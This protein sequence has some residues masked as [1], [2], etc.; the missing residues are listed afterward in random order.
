MKEDGIVVMS[1]FDGIGTGLLALK[2]AGIKVKKYYASEIE[3]K[4]MVVARNNHPEI[5]EIGDVKKICVDE[6]E[7]IDLLIGGSPCQ[8]FSR[9]GKHGNFEDKRSGLFFEWLRIWHEI[10]EKNPDAKFMLENVRMKNEWMDVISNETGVEPIIIDSRVHTQQARERTYWTNI[11]G[12]SQPHEIKTD[13]RDLAEKRDTTGWVEIDGI[14]IDPLI[15]HDERLLISRVG[16]EIRIKQA[17]KTGYI[18]AREGDGINLCFPKS[19]TRR[20]R[21]IKGKMPTLDCQCNVCFLLDGAI[22][23]ATVTE[24]ERFQGLSDGYTK[25]FSDSDR[26][27]MIGNGWS[28]MTVRHILSALKERGGES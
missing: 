9:N 10:Y 8:G 26:K 4:S 27:R 18:I 15:T 24:C 20:G 16:D 14:K 25:G 11:V 28:E 6:F 2:N 19:K 13:I 5:V 17:T 1:L 23:K 22:R 12:V 21:V 7:K 3:E